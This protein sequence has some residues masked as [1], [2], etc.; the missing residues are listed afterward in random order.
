MEGPARRGP[1]NEKRTERRI[2]ATAGASLGVWHLSRTG[3]AVSKAFTSEEN[4]DAGVPGRAVVRSA[5]GQ[6]RPITAQGHA[7]LVARRDALR[8]EHAASS[9]ERKKEL[10]H[11][12]ALI[13]ATLESVR[14]EPVSPPDGLARFGSLVT[15][16]WEDGRTQTITLV[17]PDEAESDRVSIASPLGRALLGARVGSVVEIERPRGPAEATVL[18]V[19]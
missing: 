14:I 2:Q 3:S 1:F 4:E 10:E 8:A 16:R 12:L 15:L 7:L 6:E 11:P 9:A 17:G 19:A 5:P 18:G 13:L